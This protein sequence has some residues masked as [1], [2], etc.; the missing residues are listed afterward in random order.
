[1]TV[2][3][4]SFIVNYIN[5]WRTALHIQNS[6]SCFPTHYKIYPFFIFISISSK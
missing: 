5:M 6:N 2:N 4:F 1:M 3:D